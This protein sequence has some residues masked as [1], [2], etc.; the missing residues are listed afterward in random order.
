MNRNTS[1]K[2][3]N[4]ILKKDYIEAKEQ[5]KELFFNKSLERLETKKIAVAK[6]L[7]NENWENLEE[8]IGP[9][10]VKRKNNDGKWEVFDTAQS[11]EECQD[12]I[13]GMNLSKDE[14]KNYKVAKTPSNYNLRRYNESLE[15]SGPTN[16]ESLGA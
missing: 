3:L 14:E 7:Y 8:G 2:F 6:S 4:N 5:F 13:D 15:E 12:L 9:W 16:S 11:K 10:C 1:I